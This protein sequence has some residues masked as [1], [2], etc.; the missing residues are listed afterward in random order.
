ME[1]LEKMIIIMKH[2]T[3]ETWNN[4][5]DSRLVAKDTNDWA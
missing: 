4:M 5:R 1:T 3:D 2:K